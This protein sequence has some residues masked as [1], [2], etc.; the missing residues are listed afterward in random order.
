MGHTSIERAAKAALFQSQPPVG[1][2]PTLGD[3][4]CG[5]GLFSN[6]ARH[7]GI[8]PSYAYEPDN[9]AR[10]AYATNFSVE[11]CGFIGDGFTK[12]NKPP[13]TLDL[14]VCRFPR[15]TAEFDQIALRFLRYCQPRAVMFVSPNRPTV[16][17]GLDGADILEFESSD[18]DV[19][20]HVS[21]RAGF[22]GYRMEENLFISPSEEGRPSQRHRVLV[23]IGNKRGAGSLDFPWDEVRERCHNEPKEPPRDWTTTLITG[24]VTPTTARALLGTLARFVLGVG[25]EK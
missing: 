21:R 17:V 23:G 13:H 20:R 4:F 1:E 15:D 22:L 7:L 14:L 6:A 16:N 18:G 24:E 12:D 2:T 10:A 3:L 11:P 8:I 25:S 19:T 9:E 5:A